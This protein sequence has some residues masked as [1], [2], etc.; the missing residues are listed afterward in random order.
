MVN[1]SSENL[2]NS[3]QQ[4]IRSL[5]FS[6]R[7][8]IQPF[9]W[10]TEKHGELT[11]KNLLIHNT[12][13][14]NQSLKS[15]DMSSFLAERREFAK[16]DIES[17]IDILQTKIDQIQYYIGYFPDERFDIYTGK[18]DKDIWF[19]ILA[20]FDYDKHIVRKRFK[21]KSSEQLTSKIS[22]E[23]DNTIQQLKSLLEENSFSQD[24]GFCSETGETEA[25]VIEKLL[26]PSKFLIVQSFE[27][28]HKLALQFDPEL[29]NI[30]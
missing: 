28:V 21:A 2:Y 19:G 13:W 26:K 3:L 4:L 1:S 20:P 24:Q 5:Q 6:D 23:I 8:K 30:E 25:V 18:T 10:D 9:I 16:Y 15:I 12:I 22:F 17:L 11:T 7:G 29:R 27:G 14:G